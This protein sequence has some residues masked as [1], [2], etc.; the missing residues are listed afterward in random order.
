[1]KKSFLFVFALVAI[2]LSGTSQIVYDWYQ[3]TTIESVIPGGLGRSRMITT[4]PQGILQET[5]MENFFSMVGI[6]FANVRLNDQ[7]IGDKLADLSAE[8]WELF[9]VN[10]GA[11]GHE[12]STG[13]FITRYLFRK[14]KS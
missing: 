12:A 14:V 9:Q 8:G 6:N 1:M 2:S 3:M 10:S 11:Y 7:L 13:I 4:D 5:K